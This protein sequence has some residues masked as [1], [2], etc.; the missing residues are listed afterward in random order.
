MTE[1]E[2]EK[3]KNFKVYVFDGEVYVKASDYKKIAVENKELKEQLAECEE[4]KMKWELA[5]K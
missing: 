2:L 4:D 1:E 3:L 5:A